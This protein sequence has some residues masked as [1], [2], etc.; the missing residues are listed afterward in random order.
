VFRKKPVL[1]VE[2]VTDRSILDQYISEAPCAQNALDIFADEW[3]SKFPEYL[4]LK[5]LPGLA[6]LFEDFRITWAQTLFGGFSG[7]K[8]LELGPLELGHSY[9]LHQ[10]DAERIDAVEANTRAF[11]KCLIVKEI[12]SADRVHL[13]LGD[14]VEYLRQTSESYDW[15]VASGVL[16]HMK[17]PL[18]VLDLISQRASRLLL[19]THYYDPNSI[20]SSK[21]LAGKFGSPEMILRNGVK[22]QIARYEYQ[23]SLNWSGFCGGSAEY[24]KWIT[25][26]SLIEYLGALNYNEIEIGED[27]KNHPNGPAIL[28][29]AQKS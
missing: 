29:C 5:T 9:M 7:R 10:L 27:N 26:D 25:K 12:L 20:D 8:V 3:S 1:P 24:S 17:D 18:E 6:P 2:P 11:L 13:M 28:L 14:F 22:I 16:Y 4:N 23:E 19:W 15:V 21:S